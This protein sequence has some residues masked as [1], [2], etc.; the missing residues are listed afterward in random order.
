MASL[1]KYFGITPR[2]GAET[3]LY[4]VNNEDIKSASGL[5]FKNCTPINSSKVSYD[6]ELSE[7]L[8]DYS[9][10]ILSQYV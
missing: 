8:W 3:I 5:Y 1:I 9:D 4:L 10:Q 6:N 7:K 2:E